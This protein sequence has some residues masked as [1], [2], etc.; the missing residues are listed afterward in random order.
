[1]VSGISPPRPPPSW[2]EEPL[3]SPLEVSSPVEELSPPLEPAS[4]ASELSPP[5]EEASW[6]EEALLEPATDSV[7]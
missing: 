7:K 1:M 6:L 5:L 3:S 4:L 2:E